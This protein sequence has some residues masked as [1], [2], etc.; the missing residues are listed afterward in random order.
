MADAILV[1]SV[2]SERMILLHILAMHA[3]RLQSQQQSTSPPAAVVYLSNESQQ[4]AARPTRPRAAYQLPL[5][6]SRYPPP[7][8]AVTPE[9]DASHD[10]A[11]PPRQAARAASHSRPRRPRPCPASHHAIQ[12]DQG[13]HPPTRP[14]MPSHMPLHIPSIGASCFAIL[15]HGGHPVPEVR[16]RPSRRRPM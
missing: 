3:T 16:T 13:H 2:I 12:S 4:Q 1:L 5:L 11:S 6:C 8:H 7:V 14:S 9:I 10:A 15:P